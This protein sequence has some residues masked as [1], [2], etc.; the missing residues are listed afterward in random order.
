MHTAPGNQI[1]YR[2]EMAYRYTPAS[3]RSAHPSPAVHAKDGIEPA[4]VH[5]PARVGGVSAPAWQ[6]AA[7]TK[8]GLALKAALEKAANITPLSNDEILRDIAEGR[9][10][11]H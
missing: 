9:E 7:E 4:G 1:S 2:A 3:A 6:G 8:M 11:T 5:P 10:R